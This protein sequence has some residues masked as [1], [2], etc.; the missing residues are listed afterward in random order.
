[1]TDRF[2]I[3]RSWGA[4]LL[5]EG[6]AR[7]RLWARGLETVSVVAAASGAS[8]ALAPKGDGWFEVATDAVAEDEG[9][10]FLLPD[11][12]CVPDPA[13]R[14]QIGDVHGPSRLV[15]PQAY[16]WRTP[17]WNGRPWE[18]A[19]IYELHTG[20]FSRA[21]DFDGV[22]GKLDYLVELGVTAIELM[23]VAQFGGNRGWGYDGV[24]PYAPH[25]AYG[26]PEALKRLVDAAHERGLMVL[27]DVV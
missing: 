19:I 11:G 1:L 4:E 25:I 14:A 21:G 10:A 16:T 27:L 5:P 23:P 12:T 17:A 20:P 3:E 2:G 13:A 22:R 9:Y 26:G 8:V 7:F 18:E 24:L 6:G 15:D